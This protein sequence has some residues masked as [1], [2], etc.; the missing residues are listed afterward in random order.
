[1]DFSHGRFLGV[2]PYYTLSVSRVIILN[3]AVESVARQTTYTL[4]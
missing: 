3:R 1:M 4:S 2:E